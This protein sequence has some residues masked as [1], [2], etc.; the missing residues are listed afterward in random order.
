MD[1]NQ[2]MIE[3]QR[4]ATYGTLAAALIGGLVGFLGS[5]LATSIS[6]RA[7]RKKLLL[8][9][10]VEM[11]IKQWDSLFKHLQDQVNKGASGRIVPPYVYVNFNVK[12]LE[13]LAEGKLTPETL[14]NLN[15]ENKKIIE[16]LQ[17]KK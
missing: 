2:A 14:E 13:L 16:T 12:V 6:T 3:T 8:Q 1:T 11:G 5:L 9:L 15:K 10:G 4:L 7:D 17:Q